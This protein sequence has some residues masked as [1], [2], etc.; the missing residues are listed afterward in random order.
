MT[1]ELI[2]WWQINFGIKAT[3]SVAREVS[4]EYLL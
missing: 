2:P 3:A 4:K 1:G